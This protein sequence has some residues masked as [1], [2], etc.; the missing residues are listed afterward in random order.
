[1]AGGT[2]FLWEVSP[3]LPLLASISSHYHPRGDSQNHLSIFK[4]LG[5]VFKAATTI[6]KRKLILSKD[7]FYFFYLLAAH[8][9]ADFSNSDA[10]AD[11]CFKT[12][13]SVVEFGERRSGMATQGPT[14]DFASTN[15]MDGGFS[16]SA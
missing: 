8:S 14:M 3:Q 9:L 2:S 7:D 15:R 4:R 11:T 10:H 16:W 6:E 12:K 5:I 1:M 13:N